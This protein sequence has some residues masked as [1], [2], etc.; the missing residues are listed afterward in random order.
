MTVDDPEAQPLL[1]GKP[2]D[3]PSVAADAEPSSTETTPLLPPQPEPSTWA[4]KSDADPPPGVRVNPED[5]PGHVPPEEQRRRLIWW[6]IFWLVFSSFTTVCVVLAIVKGGA[7]FDFMGSLKKAIGGGVSG[8]AAM[9]IQVLTL[10]PLRTIMNFQYRFGGTMF[11]S[12]K[13]LWREGGVTR[14]Y[15]G[16]TAALFQG[17]IA[18]FADTF[19]NVGILALLSSNPV[20]EH[21]PS[22]AKT[23]FASV[24]AALF[25][26]ILVPIDTVKTTMQTQGRAGW[27]IL[28]DRVKAYGIGTLWYGAIATAVASF[29][30][31]FPWFATY[32]WLSEV[33]PPAEGVQ[34]LLRQ[35]FIGF[36]ASV[37][38]DS[39][40]NSL[41]VLKTYRQVNQSKISYYQAALRIIQSSGY[42]SLF[43]RGLSTRIL[44]NGLQGL[45]FS[46]LWKLFQDMWEGK[47]GV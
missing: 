37:V 45:M 6:L 22:P 35:A 9:V 2:A 30:G 29:V 11:S 1:N 33:L 18:R 4:P 42:A 3:P 36:V 23:A 16:L 8:A 46:V 34:R 21:L 10:M 25:R 19:A 12:S 39:V 41:R 17:P 26:T 5:L 40:S 28:K 32:N 7:K 14:Y 31:N 24:A 27:G 13:E 38:S 44:A 47:V 15:A 20:L 43:L